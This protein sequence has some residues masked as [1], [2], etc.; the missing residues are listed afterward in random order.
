MKNLKSIEF[1][2]ENVESIVFDGKEC[3]NIKIDE[4]TES[5]DSFANSFRKRKKCKYFKALL[6]S[7]L[8]VEYLDK[9]LLD[10]KTTSPFKRMTEHKDI[11]VVMLYFNDGSG[12]GIEIDW[13]EGSEDV[14]KYQ[15][16]Y[17]NE[18]GDL[19][20]EISEEAYLRNICSFNFL[21]K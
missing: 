16:T 19:Y 1:I 4:I 10:P 13:C 12:E 6:N 14:N 3:K 8:D 9:R 11:V 17:V 15:I 7:K 21:S 20:I 5:Y 18:D 2:F